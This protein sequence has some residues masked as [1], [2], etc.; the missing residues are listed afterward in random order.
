MIA[1]RLLNQFIAVAEDL[2]F[3]R[4]AERL[5]MARAQLSQAI[6]HLGES[7]ARESSH[8]IEPE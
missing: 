6:Q 5:H 1:A 2:H 3:G 4:A 7:S 8:R